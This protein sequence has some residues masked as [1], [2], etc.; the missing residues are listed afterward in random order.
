MFVHDRHTMF[1]DS[2]TFY[3]GLHVTFDWVYVVQGDEEVAWSERGHRGTPFTCK[4][5]KSNLSP[6]QELDET[7]KWWRALTV[8]SPQQPVKDLLHYNRV[9]FDKFGKSLDDFVLHE[10]NKK[11]QIE[12]PPNLTGNGSLKVFS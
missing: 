10:K 9:Q 12:K 8:L 11:N 3:D 5:Q 4:T 2:L 7:E 1:E 6:P